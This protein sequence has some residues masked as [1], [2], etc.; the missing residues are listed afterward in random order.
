MRSII[1]VLLV[2]SFLHLSGGTDTRWGVYNAATSQIGVRETTGH[3]DGAEI[4]KYLSVTKA[5]LNAPYCASFVAW[6]FAQERVK[7]PNSAWSPDYFKKPI[8]DIR[9]KNTNDIHLCD[10]FGI[11]F[12]SMGRISHVGFIVK[13]GSS[14]VETIEA[15]TSEVNTGNRTREG[16]GVYRK[17]RLKRQIYQVSRF[18]YE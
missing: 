1:S 9:Y 18:I 17:K 12:S 13:W 14:F 15:N 11:Y 10:V 8:Y 2:L 4:E 16:Q 6:C 3:N 7:N 5:P